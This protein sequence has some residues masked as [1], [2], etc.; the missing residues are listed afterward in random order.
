LVQE[1]LILLNNGPE[2]KSSDGGNS[3]MPKR[4]WKVYYLSEKVDILD[5]MM[6]EKRII[7]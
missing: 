4:S 1:A 2:C 3:D 5:I 6:K 7:C